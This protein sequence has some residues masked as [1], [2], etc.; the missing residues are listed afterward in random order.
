MSQ[1]F[2]SVD[3]AKPLVSICCLVYNHEKFLKQ[4]LDSFLMQQTSFK[5]EVVIH[6]DASTDSSTDIIKAYE[7]KHPEI[8]KPI[9]QTENQKSKFKSGMNPRFNFPRAKGKYIAVCEGDDYWTNPLKLQKQ[10]DFLNNNSDFVLC[11]HNV[12]ILNSRGK[13][14]TETLMI[15]NTQ[16]EVFKTEDIIEK[17][18]VPTCSIM[19]RNLEDFELPN[20]F[21][22]CI[23]G[24]FPF[25]LLLSLR[26]KFKYLTN[27]MGCYRLHNT[28]ASTK[29]KG[30][31]KVYGMIFIYQNFNQFT[32]YKYESIVNK[33]IKEAINTHLP[34][35]QELNELKK[36]HKNFL[37]RTW[38]KKKFRFFLK[39]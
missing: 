26:G 28:G 3:V 23:S 33:G 35:I 6:D 15:K 34:E 18:F 39:N 2:K 12:T 38:L 7:A 19:F 20:W 8:F 25:L 30:Y 29:H 14:T 22:R 9:Y 32:N 36:Y 11:F 13:E 31:F 27:T 1:N 37:V 16:K 17:W 5:F 24:D 10:V 4:T 21:F